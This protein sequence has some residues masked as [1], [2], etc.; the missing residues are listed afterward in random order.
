M[1]SE[2]IKTKVTQLFTNRSIAFHSLDQQASAFSD[3]NTVLTKFDPKNLKAL[4]RRAF[5]LKS[6]GKYDEAVR[7]Y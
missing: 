4:Y 1:T 2:D 3:A 6:Q 7:D 5:A